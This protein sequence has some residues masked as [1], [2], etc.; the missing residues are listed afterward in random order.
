MHNKCRKLKL[1]WITKDKKSFKL[2]NES[3]SSKYKLIIYSLIQ[4]QYHKRNLQK[5]KTTNTIF[6]M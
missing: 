1:K 4:I 2:T 6:A 3:K 5:F